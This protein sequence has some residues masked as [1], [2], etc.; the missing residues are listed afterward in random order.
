LLS[1]DAGNLSG[2][3]R[4][5]IGLARALLGAP[6]LLLLDEPDA[7]LDA[8]GTDALI[9]AIRQCC[10]EGAIAIVISHRPAMVQAADLL[11]GMCEGRLSVGSAHTQRLAVQLE[12]A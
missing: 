11:I 9:G 12:T 5:R 6:R 2:G 8:E 3:M 1:N 10:A 7:S 4:Q